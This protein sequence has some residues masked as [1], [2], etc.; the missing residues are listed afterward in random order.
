MMS[1]IGKTNVA[2]ID[3]D[4]LGGGRFRY[5]QTTSRFLPKEAKDPSKQ[6]RTHARDMKT[7]GLVAA[8]TR[9]S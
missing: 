7:K 9:L 1:H 8:V 5:L 4:G 6:A 3:V 2:N